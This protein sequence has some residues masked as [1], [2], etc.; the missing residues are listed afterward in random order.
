MA[1]ARRVREQ[2]LDHRGYG[3]DRRVV[4]VARRGDA[5]ARPLVA[6]IVHHH[7]FDLGAA[8]IDADEQRV[9]LRA[10]TATGHAQPSASCHVPVAAQTGERRLDV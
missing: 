9:R 3:G 5:L 8:E 10:E 7:A 6:G 2:A 4:V 1:G